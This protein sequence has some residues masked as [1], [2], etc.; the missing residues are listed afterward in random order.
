MYGGPRLPGLPVH[1]RGTEQLLTRT[2][3]RSELVLLN[4]QSQLSLHVP[5]DAA[6][7]DQIQQAAIIQLCWPADGNLQ[8][9]TNRKV[10]FRRKE[11]S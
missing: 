6:P 7:R 8:A 10:V 4:L 11:H 2:A 5:G 3:L 1:R 9:R